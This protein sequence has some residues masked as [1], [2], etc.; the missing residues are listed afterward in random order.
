[1]WDS[2]VSRWIA[3]QRPGKEGAIKTVSNYTFPLS[4][5]TSP[6][7]FHSTAHALERNRERESERTRTKGR[8]KEERRMT[9]KEEKKIEDER[10]STENE[11]EKKNEEDQLETNGQ[12]PPRSLSLSKKK[13]VV[14]ETQVEGSSDVQT[15]S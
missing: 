11:E 1:M 3:I 10:R 14:I 12:H 9:N 15:I 8:I 2:I 7:S 5:H 13:S 4:T 6:P